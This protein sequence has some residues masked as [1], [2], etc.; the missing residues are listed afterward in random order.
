MFREIFKNLEMK[1]VALIL[2][3]MLWFHV[4]TERDYTEQLSLPVHYLN[5]PRGL[6]LLEEG[7]SRVIAAITGKGKELV[8]L[9]FL[10][11]PYVSLDL[12]QARV[13]RNALSL[14]SENIVLPPRS[15]AQASGFLSP[16]EV[17][18]EFDS[19]VSKKVGVVARM[20]S[21]PRGDLVLAG[22]F[23]VSP[24]QVRLTG[25]R[26]LVRPVKFLETEPVD[27]PEKE[28]T[29]RRNVRVV[30]PTERH[31][32]CDPQT[33]WV[34][35]RFVQAGSRKIEDVPLRIE[36]HVPTARIRVNPTSLAVTV[37]GV[38]ARLAQLTAEEVEVTLAI[39]GLA[40][41]VY[42]LPPK[43]KLPPGIS[44]VG[45]DPR[46]FSVEIK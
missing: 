33:V 10:G 14:S 39:E 22:F 15:L 35:G 1:I 6:V 13:G 43:V 21:E 12:R 8:K 31:L 2:A 24:A 40:K 44:L 11:R 29:L 7:P 45:I 38:P 46:A 36:G 41:G 17:E 32:S 19:L 5:T 23:K 20:A 3:L 9:H 27:L 28:G 42:E 34:E 25:P 18:V 4:T 26:S 37:S 16:R 30:L